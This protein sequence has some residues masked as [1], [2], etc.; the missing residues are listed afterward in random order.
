LQRVVPA[1]HSDLVAI[2]P[3]DAQLRGR[4]LFIALDALSGWGSDTSY[5]QTI[6]AAA[7]D[8]LG[9]SRRKNL[10]RH[11]AEIFAVARAHG[12]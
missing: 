4:D 5:L 11:R 9:K 2:C 1:H 10:Q 3:D 6:A 8:F 12:Q 7:R